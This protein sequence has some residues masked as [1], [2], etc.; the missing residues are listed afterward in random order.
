M[1]IRM[2]I[3]RSTRASKRVATHSHRLARS[4][5]SGYA[6]KP[7]SANCIKATIKALDFE[8]MPRE[9][10]MK[11][12]MLSTTQTQPKTAQSTAMPRL[13]WALAKTLPAQTASCHTSYTS[14]VAQLY[15]E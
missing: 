7:A 11:P 15:V 10:E 14:L 12:G 1:N 2:V 9:E 5:R 6:W 3:E 8:T 13:R 4:Q